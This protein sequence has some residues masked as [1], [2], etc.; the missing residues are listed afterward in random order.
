M[1]GLLYNIREYFDATYSGRYLAYVLAELFALSPDKFAQLVEELGLRYRRK[2]GDHVVANWWRFPGTRQERSADIAVLSARDEPLV[3]IEIKDADIKNKGN[4]AQLTDYL[5]YLDAHDDV[6]FLLLSRD[7]PP[8]S[9]QRKL[10]AAADQTRI[11]SRRF[12]ELY[13]P[14]QGKDPF[15]ALLR[16]YLEDIDVPYHHQLPDDKSVQYITRRMLGIGGR[17]IAEKSVADFFKIVFGNLTA[18]GAWI[19]AA[20]GRSF[21]QRFKRKLNVRPWYDVERILKIKGTKLERLKSSEYLGNYSTG[22][23]VSFYGNNY[24]VHASSRVYIEF[25]Y[26][27]E[28]H[29]RS[30]GYRDDGGLY[31]YFQW[32]PWKDADSVERQW[33]MRSFPTEDEAQRELR[34]LL[35]RGNGIALKKRTLAKPVSTILRAF[36]I[37]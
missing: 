16:E 8:I 1:T 28:L 22:G 37:P 36:T 5:R 17:R 13:K 30:K 31:V 21:R 27:F 33:T 7:A 11:F 6:E 2:K 26:W 15:S 35:R 25:G 20:N 19:Q 10:Q 12:R 9:S 4:S 14:L 32:K 24:L 18:L 23:M 3:L 29:K 34:N